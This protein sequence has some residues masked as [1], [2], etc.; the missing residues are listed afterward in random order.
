MILMRIDY[1][2]SADL[3]QFGDADFDIVITFSAH[4]PVFPQFDNL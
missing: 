1:M 3:E 4:G 2:K